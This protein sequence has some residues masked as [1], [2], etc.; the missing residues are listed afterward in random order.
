ML[1]DATDGEATG[2]F[3]ELWVMARHHGFGAEVVNTFYEKTVQAIAEA[4]S[5]EYPDLSK[6]ELL[7]VA[8]FLAIFGDGMAAVFSRLRERSVGPDEIIPLAIEAT[9]GLLNR[10]RDGV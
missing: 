3:L 4:M 6:Q 8:Y 5:K 7:R 10:R 2:L 1:W 9:R